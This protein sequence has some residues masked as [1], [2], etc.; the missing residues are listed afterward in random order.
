MQRN[1]L[2]PYEANPNL[3]ALSSAIFDDVFPANVSVVQF[4][5]TEMHRL[6][7]RKFHQ[8]YEGSAPYCEG[9]NFNC[10]LLFA[11]MVSK[12]H[13]VGPT[14]PDTVQR[15][16]KKKK[17]TE[18]EDDSDPPDLLDATSSPPPWT[19]LDSGQ[20]FDALLRRW[21]RTRRQKTLRTSGRPPKESADETV[22]QQTA[23]S[24][25]YHEDGSAS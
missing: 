22:P 20:R 14:L 13:N 9:I 10:H 2:S 4:K 23:T 21:M 16:T 5:V 24:P 17:V 25:V 15:K 1:F 6:L 7:R 19:S 3:Y 8:S 11:G 12:W 18:N